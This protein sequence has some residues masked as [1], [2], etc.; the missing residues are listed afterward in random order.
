MNGLPP[1]C[2]LR[3]VLFPP[4][5]VQIQNDD[6]GVTFEPSGRVRFEEC[7]S[8]CDVGLKAPRGSVPRGLHSGLPGGRPDG[9]F[10]RVNVLFAHLLC[11]EKG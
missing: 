2:P 10:F 7:C 6:K 9:V 8:N 3:F 11:K 1:W 4:T 5:K